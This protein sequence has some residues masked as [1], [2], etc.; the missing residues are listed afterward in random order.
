MVYNSKQFTETIR[1]Q[2]VIYYQINPSICAF[3]RGK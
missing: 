1:M 2:K 3:E